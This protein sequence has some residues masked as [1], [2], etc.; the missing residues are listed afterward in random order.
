MAE[1]VNLGRLGL[2]GEMFADGFI[3]R[4][5]NGSRLFALNLESATQFFREITIVADNPL[6][7]TLGVYS[8]ANIGRDQNIKTQTLTAPR[9]LLQARTNCNTWRP[10]GNAALIP[11]TVPTY[12][13]EYNGEQC[14]DSFFDNCMEKLL[15]QGVKVWDMME[16][17]EGRILL[18]ELINS[19]FIGLVNSVYNLLNFSQD[20]FAEQSDAG[21]WWQN[22]EE[23]AATWADFMD[24][25]FAKPLIGLIPQIEILKAA[26]ET[27][28]TVDIPLADVSGST[29]EGDVAVLLRSVIDAAK[30]KFR[31]VLSGR[32]GRQISSVFLVTPS[33]FSAYRQYLIDTYVG[34]PEG[35]MLLVDGVPVPGVLM[36]DG[37]PL[38]SMDEWSMY[39]ATIGINTH[40]V[41]LTALGNMVVATNIE[42]TD[43]TDGFGFV[44]EQRPELSAKGKQE[45]FTTFRLGTD[46][47]EPDFMV[48]ASIALDP[49]GNELT[50]TP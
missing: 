27:N 6:M 2:T 4:G 11:K 33:I 10:K 30:P 37:I 38:Y 5:G 23:T 8:I 9:H 31:T 13:Y 21:G 16:T 45:M 42:E 24:Q 40:R 15:A 3:G 29:Y 35:Y 26:G 28:F 22:G 39:D 7:N 43:Y 1:V 50:Y 46:I 19:I 44:V 25:Q 49:S 18:T 17:E 32:M 41:V 48:N 36:Y 12:P 34:I 20:N 14:A 47:A